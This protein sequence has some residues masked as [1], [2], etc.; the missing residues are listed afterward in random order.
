MEQGFNEQS[1][2]G[3]K[4]ARR[5]RSSRAVTRAVERRAWE[6]R[7][8][9]WTVAKIAAELGLSESGVY[10]RLQRVNQAA[11][12]ELT[13]EVAHHKLL[14]VARHERIYREAMEGWERSRQVAV[15]ET[16]ALP[17]TEV[18]GSTPP[19]TPPARG[20]EAV[21]LPEG[22]AGGEGELV[23]ESTPPLTPPLR[24]GEGA[25]PR[26]RRVRVGVVRQERTQNGDPAFLA[27]AMEALKAI[28]DLMGLDAPIKAEVT[29]TERVL[30]EYRGVDLDL[31]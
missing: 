16:R 10:V 23:S 14:L 5:G 3:G 4:R 25:A 6:L 20:G 22:S 12:R 1:E 17:E 26:G 29:F 24:G 27:R 2:A 21:D 31:I 15:I 9:G 19:L 13:Q 28:R 8:Q 11:L 18:L 30:S 7:E